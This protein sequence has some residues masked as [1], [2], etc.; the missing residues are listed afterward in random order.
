MMAKRKLIKE[1]ERQIISYYHYNQDGYSD[2]YISKIG[3]Q[4]IKLTDEKKYN[5][6]ISRNKDKEKILP[7]QL[8][9]LALT[10]VINLYFEGAK[11][12]K[13][14]DEYH[15]SFYD[16][17]VM[18]RKPIDCKFDAST[19]TLIIEMKTYAYQ[20][21]GTAD[22]KT[23]TDLYKYSNAIE[24]GKY[25]NNIFI[26]A[27]KFEDI[28]CN[29][30]I[31]LDLIYGKDKLS[32]LLN[33]G[34]FPTMF[35]ELIDDFLYNDNI[36]SPMTFLKWIGGKSK[37]IPDILSKIPKDVDINTIYWE[38]FLGSGS[39]LIAYLK[40]SPNI[41]AVI[42]T[43]INHELIFLHKM[44]KTNP[45]EL[46]DSVNVIVSEYENSDN[47]NEY[48]NL[49]RDEYNELIQKRINGKLSKE[50]IRRIA[51]LFVFLNKTCFRGIYRVNNDN[52]F[53]VPYG[54]YKHPKFIDEQQIME[55]SKLY[56]KYDVHFMC[57]SYEESLDMIKKY[58]SDFK[59]IFYFD[60]PYLHNFNAYC[61]DKFDSV[62][63]VNFIQEISKL[64]D[65]KIILSNNIGFYEH[66]SGPPKEN[67]KHIDLSKLLP[68]IAILEIQDRINP[69]YPGAIR[70]EVIMYNT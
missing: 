49:K 9:E 58:Y 40:T 68:K 21:T 65:A 33:I 34:I 22:E 36:N 25:S 31:H 26:F 12:F 28:F 32:E 54:H 24:H 45:R 1:Y 56:N 48:Y 37:L 30:P 63:F 2:D 62:K 19:N 38:M 41:K 55:I 35:S 51:A 66:Y 43:D 70:K 59:F 57:R 14:Q 42:A 27:A 20:S 67:D 23:L 64:T 8:A 11:N 5:D 3:F 15:S 46:I 13:Y 53:N 60:P 16:I 47:K 44:I 6:M 29:K 10:I 17:N 50:D 52:K 18:K 39:V 7:G 4:Y 69:K 61:I